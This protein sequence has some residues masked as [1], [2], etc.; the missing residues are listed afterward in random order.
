MYVVSPLASTRPRGSM[1]EIVSDLSP[2]AMHV[3]SGD[4][5]I[6]SISPDVS[7]VCVAVPSLVSHSL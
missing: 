3:A 1:K 2:T 6:L 4:Q 7:M 5:A